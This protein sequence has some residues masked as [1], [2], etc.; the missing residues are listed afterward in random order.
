M[1]HNQSSFESDQPR[2]PKDAGAPSPVWRPQAKGFFESLFDFG[3]NHFIT[4]SIIRA[5]YVLGLIVIG[6]VYLSFIIAAFEV[7]GAFGIISLLL[8]LI[9]AVVWAAFWRVT[10][11]FFL[12]VVRMSEDIHNLRLLRYDKEG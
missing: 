8:G 1:T 12:S 10:L 3:F 7:N 6:F 11:E 9:A 2:H 4:P 5:L